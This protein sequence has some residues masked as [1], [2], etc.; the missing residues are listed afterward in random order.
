MAIQP[1]SATRAQINHFGFGGSTNMN[2]VSWQHRLQSTVNCSKR[3]CVFFSLWLL[4]VSLLHETMF[5]MCLFPVMHSLHEHCF[6]EGGASHMSIVIGWLDCW[7]YAIIIPCNNATATKHSILSINHCTCCLCLTPAR[8]V[9]LPG[10]DVN[11]FEC[12]LREL[13]LY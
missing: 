9:R 1:W 12:W 8:Y 4:S 3:L 6:R 11:A 10:A 2:V 13:W 5:V 7:Q